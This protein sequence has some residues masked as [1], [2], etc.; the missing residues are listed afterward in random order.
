MYFE[1]TFKYFE[2]QLE[3]K[4]REVRVW[5][6][7]MNLLLTSNVEKVTE[8]RVR[9]IEV[10][11]CAFVPSR[12]FSTYCCEVEQTV[13]TLWDLSRGGSDKTDFEWRKNLKLTGGSPSSFCH[14]AELD[15]LE[16]TS[17]LSETGIPSRNGYPK[18]GVRVIAN[19]GVSE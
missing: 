3:D 13:A 12:V 18:P 11:R 16:S 5:L 8:A 10:T 1:W 4:H 2:L 19:D 14:I 9:L 15:G 6:R 7:T 17:H